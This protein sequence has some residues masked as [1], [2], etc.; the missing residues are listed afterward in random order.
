M[1]QSSHPHTLILSQA[2]TVSQAQVTITEYRQQVDLMSLTQ[3]GVLQLLLQ[4][5]SSA[6]LLP[7]TTGHPRGRLGCGVSAMRRR[8]PSS[9]GVHHP[10]GMALWACRERG[11]WEGA[12]RWRSSV[13]RMPL[14]PP[15][16]TG[17]LS[18]IARVRPH[19]RAVR[20]APRWE[21]R[22]LNPVPLGWKHTDDDSDNDMLDPS[23]GIA[24]SVS[25]GR[26][27]THH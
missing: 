25:T 9:G 13:D 3:A 14:P 5:P 21:A 1:L 26:P 6:P 18:C 23:G 4:D 7:A 15:C 8:F 19:T 22:S 11:T 17:L 12:G 20:C 16:R 27:C 24:S 2:P 10:K